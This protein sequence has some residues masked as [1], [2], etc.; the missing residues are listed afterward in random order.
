MALTGGLYA[1]VLEG[2]E[3]PVIGDVVQG[4]SCSRGLE[5]TKETIRPDIMLNPNR[6]EGGWGRR[7]EWIWNVN[8]EAGHTEDRRLVCQQS[9][10]GKMGGSNR[11]SLFIGL[12]V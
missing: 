12:G 1:S 4:T 3:R 11:S 9:V 2:G 8:E 5:A 10:K 6:Y 7:G